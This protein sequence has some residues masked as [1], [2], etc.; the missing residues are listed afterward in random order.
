MPRICR[1][2]IEPWTIR[3]CNWTN[4]RLNVDA[5]EFAMRE[6]FKA[7]RLLSLVCHSRVRHS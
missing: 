5:E 7:V 4:D 3:E 6:S 2:A 1:Q